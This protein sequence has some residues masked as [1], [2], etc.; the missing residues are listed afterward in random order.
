MTLT[1]SRTVRH[2][3]ILRP[4]GCTCKAFLP[5]SGTRS[6]PRTERT[7]RGIERIERSQSA[8]VA[9]CDSS[10]RSMRSMR[11]GFIVETRLDHRVITE[12]AHPSR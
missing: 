5:Q 1:R 6:A 7:E 11:G 9:H 8:T 4:R 3:K 12:S 2:E 10:M